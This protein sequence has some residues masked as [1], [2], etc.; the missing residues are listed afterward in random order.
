MKTPRRTLE[1]R[2]R[3]ENCWP[4]CASVAG[5][6]FAAWVPCSAAAT[7]RPGSASVPQ[8][9]S[10]TVAVYARASYASFSS[11]ISTS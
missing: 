2:E 4:V 8:D 7:P 10:H 11:E 6:A 3:A 1:Y 9:H 5:K